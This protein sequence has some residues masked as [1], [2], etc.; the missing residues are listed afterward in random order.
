MLQVKQGFYTLAQNKQLVK[1]IESEVN[2]ATES[3]RLVEGRYQA[4]LGQF[5]DV[6]DAQS[7]LT[8]ARTDLV[9]SK[10]AVD[11]ARAALAHAV[12]AAPPR[13]ASK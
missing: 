6:L 1:T 12:G 2:N 3:L 11:Q 7:T 4:G 5:L 10:F 13:L 8:K 9:N